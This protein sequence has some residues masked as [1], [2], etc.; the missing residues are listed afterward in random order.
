MR[1]TVTDGTGPIAF[2]AA[3]SRQM[4]AERE[5]LRH[6]LGMPATT[7]FMTATGAAPAL[8][9]SCRYG[10]SRE[11]GTPDPCARDVGRVTID[12]AAGEPSPPS[13]KEPP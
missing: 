4:T 5:Y 2:G 10:T 11:G 13:R 6:A 7:V 1:A 8:T 3:E 9:A 12:L